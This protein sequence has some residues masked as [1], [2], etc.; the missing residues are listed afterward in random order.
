MGHP[1]GSRL[2]LYCAVTGCT[3][4]AGSLSFEPYAQSAGIDA[5]QAS[6]RATQMIFMTPGGAC[7]DFNRDGWQDLFIPMGGSEPDRLYINQGDGTFSEQAAAWGV[8]AT[9]V[10][11][12][13]AVGDYDNDGWL[14][15]YVTSFGTLAAPQPSAH[16]LY[17]NDAGTGFSEVALLAG[18]NRTSS[19][20]VDGFGAAFGDYDLDGDLDL[21]VA[22]WVQNSGGNRLFRNEGDGTFMDVTATALP[23]ALLSVRGLS[24]RFVDMTDDRFPEL[25]WVGDFGTSKY[26]VNDGAGNFRDETAAA[27]LGLD[28]NG[29]GGASGDF[30][31]D[32]RLDWYVTSIYSPATF[33]YGNMLYINSGDGTFAEVGAAAGVRECYWAWGTAAVDWD[34]DAWQDLAVTNGWAGSYWDDN[35]AQLFL[36]DGAGAFVEVAQ[37]SGIDYRGQGR[38]LLHVDFDN[39]LDQDLAVFGNGEPV[40]LFRNNLSGEQSHALRIFLDTR[41]RGGL[42]PD[43]FGTRVTVLADGV[44]QV[45]Y[46]DGGC[47]YLSQSELSLHFGLAASTNV[48]ELRIDWADGKQTLLHDLAAGQTITVRAGLAGDLDADH[49]VDLTDLSQMLVAFAAC[50]DDGGYNRLADLNGDACVDVADLLRL[51]EDFGRRD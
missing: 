14:D 35:P 1:L 23:G 21:A 38:G 33:E 12:G 26:L 16:R 31:R 4:E 49:D 3:A 6:N 25:L 34:H 47:S 2:W 51:L 13:A 32:Q 10:G 11:S 17:H 43:G 15:L 24:M 50:A 5:R 18:V 27:G 39:D 40:A 29:M 19:T 42:A 7:G 48:A 44:E 22:G 8:A 45:R 41:G 30:N 20:A 9:H 37:A 28:D 36:N 46:L